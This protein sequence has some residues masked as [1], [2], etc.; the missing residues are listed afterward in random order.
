MYQ[1]YTQ[2]A[3]SA[4]NPKKLTKTVSFAKTLKPAQPKTQ[5]KNVEFKK[6]PLKVP[7]L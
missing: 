3:F 5:L 7:Y 4:V 6:H 2:K 1:T